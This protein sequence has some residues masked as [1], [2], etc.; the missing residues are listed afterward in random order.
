MGWTNIF[1]FSSV[2]EGLEPWFEKTLAPAWNEVFCDGVGGGGVAAV[3]GAGRLFAISK[4]VSTSR[5]TENQNRKTK[6]QRK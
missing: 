3:F 2:E 1:V 5:P 4:N 6:K